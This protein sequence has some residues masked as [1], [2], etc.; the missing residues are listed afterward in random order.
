MSTA[1]IATPKSSVSSF[2]IVKFILNPSVSIF[3][4]SVYPA[5]CSIFTESLIIFPWLSYVTS[6]I[7][8]SAGNWYPETFLVSFI[9]YLIVLL[10]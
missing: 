4:I 8:S 5:P 9:V 7:K 1:V 3:V 2:V 10:A 6:I